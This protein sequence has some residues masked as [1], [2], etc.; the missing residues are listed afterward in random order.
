MVSKLDLGKVCPSIWGETGA[1]KFIA[2]KKVEAGSVNFKGKKQ[3]NF[4]IYSKN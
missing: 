3:P 4:Q 2:I 1:S